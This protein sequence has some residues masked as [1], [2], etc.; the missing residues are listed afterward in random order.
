[1]EQKA[2]KSYMEKRAYQ[3]IPA[4]EEVR[5]SYRNVFYSGT[6]LNLSEKGMFIG[7]KQCFPSDS[8]FLILIGKKNDFMKLFAKVK[9]ITEM[10][11]Y[12][13]GIGVELLSFSQD[14]LNFIDTLKHK[15]N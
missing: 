6:V 1:M 14:Y 7:T 2:N 12:Y 10:N 5:V 3:R 8:T 11:G 13:D 9:R 15:S 4:G